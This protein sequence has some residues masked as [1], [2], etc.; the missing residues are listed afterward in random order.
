VTFDY[1]V[2]GAGTAGCILARRLSDSGQFTVL[3]IE[4][5]GADRSPWFK[6][7]A[8][9][10]KCYQDP[11]CNWMYESS[12]QAALEGRRLYM[13]RG[14]VQGGSGTINA[15]IYVRGQRSD[16]DDWR[17][18][19]NPDWGFDDVLPVFRQLE[20]HPSGDTPF[21]GSRGPIGIT[22]MRAFA[23]PVCQDYLQACQE[24]NLPLNPDFNGAD[25]EGAGI[26]DANIRDGRR[27][28]TSVAYLHPVQGRRNLTIERHALVRRLELDAQ[29][30]AH[31]VE[32]LQQGVL[33]RFSARREIVLCAG[34]VGSPSV[35]QHSGIGD[36]T[37]LQ[38]LGVPTVH[39]LPAVGENLQDH[40]AAWFTYR[41]NRPTLNDELRSPWA[42]LK[43][44]L[45]YLLTRGGPLALSV[46]QAGGFFRGDPTQT[47]PNLQLYFNPLSYSIP[48]DPKVSV[49]P[50]PFPGVLLGFNACR[51]TSRG[52]VH[53]S[54]PD[55]HLAPC[56]APNYLATQ[57][58]RDE[59]VQGGR[60]VQR[61]AATAALSRL[62]AGTTQASPATLDDAALLAHVRQTASSIYHLCGSCAMGP[63]AKLSVVDS[64]LRVHGV[65]GLR[66]A[67]ASIF[68]NITSG[69][70]QAAVMMVA[71]RAAQWVM[72]DSRS[73]GTLNTQRAS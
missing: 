46:N 23:H 43:V 65:S 14:K 33:R 15:M 49:R 63:D 56:I 35:L 40:L 52:K 25:L 67:D 73:T 57:Q 36:G 50:D 21:H 7:P 66:I 13:P 55:P 70:T 5:G 3:L 10:V 60:L 27:D 16:F 29:R 22:P 62:M 37:T 20:S 18:A 2:I 71:E 34:A 9:Y 6:I 51:P 41:V 42:Q 72:A 26:Y 58:D 68:P 12:A 8:G 44:G 24:L 28:S 59:A 45:R 53:I 32:V 48:K 1:I 61:L 54:S 11:A 30:R 39:H 69:N 4:A 64:K 19:G 47:Q 38:G 31:S 17:T